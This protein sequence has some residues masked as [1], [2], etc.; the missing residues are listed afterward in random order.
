MSTKLY[1]LELDQSIVNCGMSYVFSLENGGFF[2]IDGGY[3]TPGEED[4]LYA[5]LRSKS[6]GEPHIK[7][8]FFTHAHQDHIGCFINF[9]EKYHSSVKIDKLYY[10]FQPM[11]Y[12]GAT[13]SWQEKCNDLATVKHFYEIIKKYESYFE[14]HT[15][16]TDEVINIDELKLTVLYTQENLYPE[17][18]SFND[19]SAVISIE[20]K[21]QRIVFLGDVQDKGSEY[22]VKNKSGMLKSDLAQVAHHG[23]HGATREL[24]SHIQPQVL[25]FPAPDYEFEKN[26]GSEV[27]SYILNNLGVKEVIVSGYGT[28]ELSLPYTHGT[29]VKS[30]KQF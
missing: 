5:F 7:G 4:N 20:T 21:G 11:D 2:I 28:A 14:I 15:L 13:G 3:F 23:F 12:P 27:N 16:K 9:I 17:K 24:Y 18:A 25:L 26:A 30:P 6:A 29:S 10:N 22:L 1:Q 19:Y 8:W